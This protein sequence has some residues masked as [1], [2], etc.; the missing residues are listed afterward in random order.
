MA[1]REPKIILITCM[2][3]R[4]ETVRRCNELMP[5]IDKYYVYSTEEDGQFLSTL[6]TS[7]MYQTPNTPLS[8]K[9]NFATSLLKSIDFDGAVFMGSDDYFDLNFYSFVKDN[10]NSY[11]VIGFKDLYIKATLEQKLFRGQ[12]ITRVFQKNPSS[13]KALLKNGQIIRLSKETYRQY[14]HSNLYTQTQEETYYWKG[15]V[16]HRKD[17]PIGA[18]K[19][20]SKTFLEKIKYDLFPGNVNKG[21]DGVSWRKVSN[22][23]PKKL[24]TTLKEHDLHLYDIKDKDSLT[25]F[26]SISNIVEVVL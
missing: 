24:V 21:L 3:G 1:E 12:K 7:G 14:L 23:N 26:S 4:H 8:K 9:W 2:H 22:F 19:V 18:G 25:K 20:Y 5:F 17:E 10:I 6:Q 16:T 11:D 13:V 15:Y